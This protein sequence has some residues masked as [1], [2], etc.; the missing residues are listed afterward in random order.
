VNG[1]V[2]RALAAALWGLLGAGI[3][4][5]T[6]ALQRYTGSQALVFGGTVS[7]HHLTPTALVSDS[8]RVVRIGEHDPAIVVLGYTRCADRCPMTLATVSRALG[9]LPRASG[10]QAFFLTV[11][12]VY[13]TPGVLHRYLGAWQHR[14]VGLTGA[15]GVVRG[16]QRELGA[17][18]GL[19]R[20]HDTR[21]FLLDRSGDVLSELPP[22]AAVDDVRRALRSIADP[23]KPR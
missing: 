16:V 20:D 1:I 3:F 13:D 4:E 9:E 2:R 23:A 17:G 15:P 21:L 7:S 10:V 6:W 12:P 22:E 14:I 11:D 5:S 8:G 18:G 19:G